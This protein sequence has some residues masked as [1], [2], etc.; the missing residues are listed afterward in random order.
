MMSQIIT[1]LKK[2]SLNQA[3]IF[4]INFIEYLN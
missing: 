2:L 1:L 3:I 4:V